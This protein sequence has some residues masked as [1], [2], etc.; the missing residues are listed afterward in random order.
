VTYRKQK[1]SRRSERERGR[2]REREGERE[3]ER[4]RDRKKERD[5]YQAEGRQLYELR[6]TAALV[7]TLSC[8]P[9]SHS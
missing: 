8:T 3:R 5:R 9:A 7:R 6:A 2:G 4:E 1:A